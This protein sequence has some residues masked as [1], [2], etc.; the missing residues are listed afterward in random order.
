MAARTAAIWNISGVAEEFLRVLPHFQVAFQRSCAV[1]RSDARSR[2]DW[3]T[4]AR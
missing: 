3:P 1:V 4:S 2:P